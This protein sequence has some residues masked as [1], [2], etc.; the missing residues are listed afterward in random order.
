LTAHVETT[1]QKAL[2]H[3]EQ[4]GMGLVVIGGNGSQTGANALSL[5]GIS[6]GGCCVHD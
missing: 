3:L 2:A 4:W 6:G 5:D 1:R